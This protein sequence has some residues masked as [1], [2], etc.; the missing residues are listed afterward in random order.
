VFYVIVIPAKAGIQADKKSK[1]SFTFSK[2]KE[3]PE[4]RGLFFVN[5]KLKKRSKD[6]SNACSLTIDAIITA[7]KQ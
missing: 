7:K 6:G 4:I 3:A 2:T 5:C 1:R